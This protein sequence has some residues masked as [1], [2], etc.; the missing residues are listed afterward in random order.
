MNSATHL[1]ADT[2][3][4]ILHTRDNDHRPLV[5]AWEQR[6]GVR[7]HEP[8]G[9]RFDASAR[10]SVVIPARDRAY[11]IGA[12][13]D[14]LHAQRPARDLEIIVVDDDSGDRTPE[15]VAA[16]PAA[17]VLVR[18]PQRRGPGAARN[19][20]ASRA[21]GETLLFLDADMVLPPGAVHELALRASPQTALLGFFEEVRYDRGNGGH[22]IPDRTPRLEAD[23]R[24]LWER[25]RGRMVG[26]DGEP[27][28]TPE[29]IRLLD[30]T[31][32][33]ADLGLGRRHWMWDLPRTVLGKLFTVPRRSLV[34]VGGFHPS[35]QGWGCEETHL[36]ALL[37]A[38]GLKVVPVRC[39]S[40]YHLGEPD[41]SGSLREKMRT[42]PG[43][44]DQYRRLLGSPPEPDG[45]A[46]FADRVQ[47]ALGVH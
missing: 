28:E 39:V 3:E 7:W 38:S 29:R 36:A 47:E 1:S 9:G 24:V 5:S 30:D 4:Q 43:N 22:R 37:I 21:T 33:L 46:R 16:H 2:L 27:V 11:S 6:F 15:I 13:L 26:S 18:L 42:W 23:Y 19:A 40:G 45:A 31:H 10:L 8:S 41:P 12:V 17:P 20:G 34:E 35:F 25:G 32:D 14:A 44:L